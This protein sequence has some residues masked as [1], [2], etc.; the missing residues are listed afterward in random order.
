M[1]V[2]LESA[3]YLPQFHGAI[4]AFLKKDAE[5]N[6][7]AIETIE[8]IKAGLVVPKT[9]RFAVDVNDKNEVVGFSYKLDS[10]PV[11]FTAD[12]DRVSEEYL[13]SVFTLGDTIQ[14]PVNV[15]D[16][17]FAIPSAPK[18]TVEKDMTIML[19]CK[20]TFKRFTLIGEEFALRENADSDVPILNEML[21]EF[22]K[23]VQM[24]LA[25][26][27]SIPNMRAR[28]TFYVAAHRETDNIAACTYI[29][30]VDSL[31][32]IS[33]VYTR[34]AFRKKGLSKALVSRAISDLIQTGRDEATFTL[35]VQSKNF[36]AVSA[37]TAVGFKPIST[38]QCRKLIR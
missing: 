14:G 26:F 10:Y 28:G 12:F 3:E 22:A 20:E 15:L 13:R 34:P 35:F 37:Y 16:R 19:C 4:L 9:F 1:P 2:T 29:T 33:I 32:R 38:N 8:R 30:T 17:L 6:Q 5:V 11:L 21:A 36:A 25:S 18:Y 7:R 27:S 23:D 31:S 24:D